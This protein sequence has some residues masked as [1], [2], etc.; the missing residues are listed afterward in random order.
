M[1]VAFACWEIWGAKYPMFPRR[2]GK[3][4]RTLVLLLVITFVAGANFFAVIMLWPSQAYNVYGHDPVGVGV[5]GLPFA[6]GVL[7]G[8]VVNL[9][10]LTWSRVGIRWLTL[11]ASCVMT[12]GCGALA[13]ATRDNIG[14]V[15][16]FLFLA[17]LGVGGV[18]LPA[19]IAST[20]ICPD[21]L[22]A[23]VTSLTLA[24]RV[25]GGA[26]G[27]TVYYNVF[28]S[29]VV[30]LLARH[31]GGAMVRAGFDPRDP[32]VEAVVR[33]TGQAMIDEIGALPAVA[34]EPGL[35]ER[36]VVAGQT[37]FA[38]AYPWVYYCSIA[39]GGLAIVSSLFLEDISEFMNDHVAVVI[40]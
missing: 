26:V 25:V 14:A 2:L 3:K 19:A 7:A 12:A 20:I 38:E 11:G 29:K 21:D 9:L 37:G 35:F 39:F 8:C 34:A 13:A 4:P 16:A 40:R 24:V 32:L 5:R 15:Y 23:T 36:L 6:F 27:Y 28:Y 31:V 22:I 1:V 17:G 18:V 33:M 10:L 30:P